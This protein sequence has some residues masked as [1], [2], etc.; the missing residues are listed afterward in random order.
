M[1]STWAA[2]TTS[3]KSSAMTKDCGCCRY[4]LGKA[5]YPNIIL[6]VFVL[7]FIPF[8]TLIHA[9]TR[10]AFSFWNW[11]V[12]LAVACMHFI[13]YRALPTP[14]YTHLFPQLKFHCAWV[15]LVGCIAYKL[16]ECAQV[17]LHEEQHDFEENRQRPMC[18]RK[19]RSGHVH[20]CGWLFHSLGFAYSK[21]YN[22][23]SVASLCAPFNVENHVFV[24]HCSNGNHA[25][26]CNT[27]DLVGWLI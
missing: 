20:S 27:T 22:M 21:C 25:N 5:A 14:S 17:T 4:S 6:G 2:S 24:S 12:F 9:H 1:A 3:R 19:F 26:V 16:S 11:V 23:I 7:L 13:L 8:I 10:L 15:P 18:I